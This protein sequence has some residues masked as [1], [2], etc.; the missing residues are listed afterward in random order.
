MLLPELLADDPDVE[1]FLPQLRRV[2]VP[3][4]VRV[5]AIVDAR[6]APDNVPARNRLGPGLIASTLDERRNSH[7]RDQ[8][9]GRRRQ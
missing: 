2:R 5:H 9:A 4:P 8:R 3:Q 7:Q 6:H 1:A